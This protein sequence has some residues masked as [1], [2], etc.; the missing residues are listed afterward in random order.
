MPRGLS[1]TR[2]GR[3]VE[4]WNG[5]RGLRIPWAPQGEGVPL[6]GVHL[7]VA[8]QGQMTNGGCLG[9]A[10]FPS[11]ETKRQLRAAKLGADF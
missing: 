7:G 10:R 2:W 9:A 4:T 5:E 6:L 8:A 1:S 11:T 3:K